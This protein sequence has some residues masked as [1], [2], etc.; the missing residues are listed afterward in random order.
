[1]PY[2]MYISAAGADVQQ[3]RLEILTNNLANVDTPGF[4]RELAILQARHA[5]AIERGNVAAGQGQLEDI[6]GGVELAETVTD[7]T[8]GSF[9]Q[10]GNKTDLAIDGEGFFQ[11]EKD[12]Q[13]LLTRAG[14]F[15]F[16]PTGQLQTEQGF[17]VLSEDGDPVT[18]DPSLPW[19]AFEDGSLQQGGTRILLSLVKPN[20]LGD[21]VKAGNNL[22]SPLAEVQPVDVG[23][24]HVLS[25]YVEQSAVKPATEM[26]QLIETSRAYEANIKLIQNHDHMIGSLVNRVLRQ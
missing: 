6:G 13:P 22:F 11:V 10:T 9:R 1:M 7:F 26:M 14:N 5:E 16:S 15:H 20:S 3:R 21:L 17:P 12:G 18:L 23:E 19:Q 24:R 25:G 4:K 2:G 8:A